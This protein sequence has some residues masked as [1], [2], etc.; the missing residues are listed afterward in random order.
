[1]FSQLSIHGDSEE[2]QCPS[3]R[4]FVM[5]RLSGGRRELVMRLSQRLLTAVLMH[6]AHDQA[7]KLALLIFLGREQQRV[8]N[9]L[10]VPRKLV[11][12]V[13]QRSC[14]SIRLEG[15]SAS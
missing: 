10:A 3:A 2:H 13:P 4:T 7:A 12:R 8:H 11:D 14:S 15:D 1:M 9:P 5:S 6:D